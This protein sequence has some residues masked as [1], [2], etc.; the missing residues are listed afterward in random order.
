MTIAPFGASE[1]SIERVRRALEAHDCRPKGRSNNFI[2]LCPVHGDSNASLSVTYDQSGGRTLVNC[3]TCKARFDDIADAIGLTAQDLFD[4]P[5]PAREDRPRNKKRSTPRKKLA[6]IPA[7]LCRTITADPPASAW[8]ETAT[9]AYTDAQ[10]TLVQEVVREEADHDGNHHKRFKQ[11]YV[12]DSTGRMVQRKPAGFEPV[13]YRAPEVDHALKTGQIIWIVEGEKDADNAAEQGVCAT[14]NAQGALSFPTELLDQLSGASVAIA[15]DRDKAGWTRAVELHG[16]LTKRGCTTQILA[17]V[18]TDAKADLSDHLAAGY[19]INQLLPVSIDDARALAAAATA[20]GT[21]EQIHECRDEAHARLERGEPALVQRWAEES[22]RLLERVSD[23]AAPAVRVGKLGADALERHTDVVR[24][25]A[26]TVRE[27]FQLANLNVPDAVEKRHLAVL[28]PATDDKPAEGAD[29]PR[30]SEFLDDPNIGTDYI[31]RG[32]ETVLIKLERNGDTWRKRYHRVI[33]GWAEIESVYVEDD[34]LEQTSARSTHRVT[35]NFHRW[36]RDDAG[37]P[38]FGDD[39]AH[40]IETARVSWDADQIRDGSWVNA[41]PWPAMLESTSR[42]GKDTAWDAIHNARQAP[43]YR[44]PVYTA[45]G[46]RQTDTGRVYVHGS[47]AI[48]RGGELGVAVELPGKFGQHYQL[49][50][51]SRD[52][53]QL[54]QAWLDGAVPLT[55]L[56]AR[57]FAP[58]L[59]T[60]WESVWEPAPLVTHLYGGRGSA[61]TSTARLGMQF[62]APEL[63]HRQKTHRAIMSAANRGSSFIGISRALSALRDVPVL[64]DDLAPDGDPAAAEQKLAEIARLLYNGQSRL[65]GGQKGG[66]RQDDEIRSTVITTGELTTTGSAN[67]RIMSIPIDLGTYKNTGELFARLETKHCRESRGLLGASLIEWLAENHDRISEQQREEQESPKE[68]ARLQGWVSRIGRLPF[69]DGL[70]GRLVE[71]AAAAHHGIGLMLQMLVERGALTFDEANAVNDWAVEGI[72]QAVALQPAELGD[73]G[74]Q[75]LRLIREGLSSGGCYIANPDGSPPEEHLALGWTHRQTGGPMSPD[76]IVP[77]SSNR[78]GVIKGDRLYL[79]PTVALSVAKSVARGA[80]ETFAE[81]AVSVSSALRGHGWISPDSAGKSATVRRINGAVARVWD[82]PLEVLLGEDPD[83]LPDDSLPPTP[84]TPEPGIPA[85]DEDFTPEAPVEQPQL[86]EV[87]VPATAAPV[88]TP[89]AAAHAVAEQPAAKAAPEQHVTRSVASQAPTTSFRAAAAVLDA[90]HQLY[91]PGA[92]PILLEQPIRHLGDI[93][94]LTIDFK[95]GTLTEEWTLADGSKRS[96]REWGQIWLTREA[97]I[98]LGIPLEQLPPVRYQLSNALKEL[99][100]DHPI[101]TD[102]QLD[103]WIINASSLSATTRVKRDNEHGAI[104]TIAPLLGDDAHFVADNPTPGDLA[105]RLQAFADALRYPYTVSA[106]STAF[107]LMDATRRRSRDSDRLFA[108]TPHIEPHTFP[109]DRDL[110]WTRQLTDAE[111]NHTYVHGYDRGGSYLAAAGGLSFGIGAA[112]HRDAPTFDPKKPLPGYWRI[113]APEHEEWL[114]PNPI[115]SNPGSTPAGQDLWVTT[116]RLRYAIECGYTDIEIH[117]AWV[118]TEHKRFLE[119]WVNRVR[120]ARTSLDTVNP[121]DQAARKVL[122][123]LYVRSFG[124][125]DSTTFRVG[126]KN[127]APERFHMIQDQASVNILRLVNKIGTE[128]GRWPVAIDKDLILYTSDVADPLEAWPGETNKLGRGLGQYKPELTGNLADVLPHLT[129]A[130]FRGKD[131]M[132]YLK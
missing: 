106:T 90:G 70:R 81:T 13:F 125:M 114:A 128:Q 38:M 6:P 4:A 44:K 61:K 91:I 62:V 75:L 67:T 110:H 92:A 129:G 40:I 42:R 48:A 41:L 95:L 108:P 86:I 43:A 29:V 69:D 35:V 63:N 27:V 52:A 56:P 131:A 82:L 32:G 16:E 25:A 130:A 97:A 64:V 115:T 85:I 93:A 47:D 53:L 119:Q 24:E 84:L 111:L 55:E 66:I 11:R 107:N 21:L 45:T 14:T 116:P 100:Q 34:G 80:Q 36:Q 49:P 127:F 58:L 77:T 105:N 99:T 30:I 68:D 96:R 98:E 50:A 87:E 28:V 104:I 79:F 22:E 37:L 8:Q 88:E 112:E 73:A 101:I 23:P 117:E 118:W 3:F 121:N 5:L 123:E 60:I 132:K 94:Q 26:Q 59:G 51:P 83:E 7:R 10:A 103:G 31:V 74:H 12:N 9:Y 76:A 120:D 72:V 20:A 102:A 17:P 54:R 113:T 65:V 126:K 109:L 78:V 89:A 1:T 2:A 124:M 39:G 19:S 46:W 71:G 122:K 57:I 33:R 15:A 18:P